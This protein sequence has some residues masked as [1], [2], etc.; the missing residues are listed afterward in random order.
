MEET[1]PPQPQT[2]WPAQEPVEP[3]A[4]TEAAPAEAAPTVMQPMAT[5]IPGTQAPAGQFI[6]GQPMMMAGGPQQ[7]VYIPLKFSPQPNYRTWSYIA[8]GLAVAGAFLGSFIG[9]ILE[10][11]ALGDALNSL[12]CCGGFTAAI[13]L[14]VAYYKGKADW[15]TANGMSS[16]GS[17]VS[18]V[19]EGILGVICAVFVVFVFIGMLSGF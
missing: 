12:L 7:V 13:F 4:S 16:T 17:T 15:Q 2:I 19:L 14:D 8:I 3:T 1:T 6:Q 10:Q 18:M 9:A 11:P 5:A